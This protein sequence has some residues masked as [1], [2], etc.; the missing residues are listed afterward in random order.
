MCDV[1]FHHH[2]SKSFGMVLLQSTSYCY[3]LSKIKSN[4]QRVCPI[5]PTLEKRGPSRLYSHLF[6]MNVRM[7]KALN[8]N[9]MI[10]NGDSRCQRMYM[11]SLILI[12]CHNQLLFKQTTTAE[13]SIYFVFI[14]R[15]V[16][17]SVEFEWLAG[18]LTWWNP[19]TDTHS[20]VS[21]HR[22]L[23]LPIV[24]QT[25]D[26]TENN[27]IVYEENHMTLPVLQR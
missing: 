10:L 4:T 24:F 6:I 23:L 12:R 1:C 11:P 14:F 8:W 15:A 7:P 2:T 13:T 20:V 19:S 5:P 9:G 18:W 3:I 26:K 21:L 16:G 22:P 27:N 25:T 17:F